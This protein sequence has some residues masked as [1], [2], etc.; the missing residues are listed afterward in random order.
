[1]KRDAFP[2]VLGQSELAHLGGSPTSDYAREKLIDPGAS[3]TSRYLALRLTLAAGWVTDLAADAIAIALD[4]Q[5]NIELR[6]I[7]ARV[8][9]E[10]P[11]RL[12]TLVRL[13]EDIDRDVDD[14]EL[15]ELRTMILREMLER[16]RITQEDAIPL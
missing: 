16:D 2:W 5:E 6:Q 12:P 1:D 4:G 14:R 10:D 8:A 7:G 11:S 13:V 3:V 9:L 15:A